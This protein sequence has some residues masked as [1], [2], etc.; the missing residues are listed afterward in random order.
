MTDSAYSAKVW[1]TRTEEMEDQCNRTR[2]KV[3]MIQ[4]K[5]DGG[6]SNYSASGKGDGITAQSAHED[7][8]L[9]Y[10]LLKRQLEEEVNRYAYELRI[11]FQVIDKLKN[12]R[13]RSI[14]IARYI[15]HEDWK[16]LS[17]NPCI[18]LKKSRL[19]AF[20]KQALEELALILESENTKPPKSQT[21]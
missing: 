16:S 14:L 17:N 7:L 21:K 13:H 12:P 10:S 9:E 5:L 15:N 4:N 20:H 19:I 6:V 11:S 18:G 8:L 1:L 3:M 2:T